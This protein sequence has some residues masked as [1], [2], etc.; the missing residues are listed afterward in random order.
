MIVARHGHKAAR[1]LVQPVH[2]V[3][4]EGVRV[5]PQ[6]DAQRFP[7]RVVAVVRARQRRHRRG[8]GDDDLVLVPVADGTAPVFG[9]QAARFI[10]GNGMYA[11]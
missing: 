4:A 3:V 1:P 5:L 7:Q 11:P 9:G 10:G 8:L 2:R 6:K